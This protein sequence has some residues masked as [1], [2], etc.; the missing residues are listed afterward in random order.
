MLL[1][2]RVELEICT[3]S[4]MGMECLLITGNQHFFCFDYRDVWS[5]KGQIIDSMTL[6]GT[7]PSKHRSKYNYQ[8][9]Q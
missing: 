7:S 4:V 8:G 2:V 1:F 6:L 3:M 5:V 9:C